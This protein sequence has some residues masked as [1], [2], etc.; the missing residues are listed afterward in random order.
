MAARTFDPVSLNCGDSLLGTTSCWASSSS[1]AP[2]VCRESLLGCE[3]RKRVQFV[4][5]MCDKLIVEGQSQSS[6]SLLFARSMQLITSTLTLRG[7]V[8]G[9]ATRCEFNR[10]HVDSFHLVPDHTHSRGRNATTQTSSLQPA[11]RVLSRAL[12]SNWNRLDSF[13]HQEFS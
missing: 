12:I 4:I 11:R 6:S 10:R 9:R 8:F 5:F 7:C 2:A 1:P 3:R 13:F